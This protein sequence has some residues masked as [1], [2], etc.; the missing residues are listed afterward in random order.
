VRRSA[1]SRSIST[2]PKQAYA[3]ERLEE[4]GLE[5]FVE[6][7]CGDALGIVRA[8]EGEW[9]LVLLDIWKDLYVP[10]FEAVYPRL[11]EEG[12]IVSDNMIYPEGRARRGAR[13]AQAIRA[14]GR[15]ADGAAAA[16]ERDRVDRAVERGEREAVRSSP[17]TAAR[18]R[19]LRRLTLA[20]PPP[21]QHPLGPLGRQISRS[22]R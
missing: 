4:A 1:W 22:G 17:P 21:R 9:G 8:D 20:R 2:P 10:C 3:R 19:R 18:V 12:L 15:P 6:F 16:G 14:K 13:A 11:A 5:D 7:R